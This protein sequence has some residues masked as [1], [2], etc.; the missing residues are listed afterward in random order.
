MIFFSA[1]HLFSA[2]SR[3]WTV[4][5]GSLQATK[6]LF[7]WSVSRQRNCWVSG[8]GQIQAMLFK[9]GLGFGGG[10]RAHVGSGLTWVGSHPRCC[11]RKCP[12]ITSLP[13]GQWR[14]HEQEV[15]TIWQ[16]GQQWRFGARVQ[17]SGGLWLWRVGG[18]T[19]QLL[20]SNGRLLQR[21]KRPSGSDLAGQV[22]GTSVLLPFAHPGAL[23]L[24][25]V[26]CVVGVLPGW[27]GG[28]RWWTGFL[29]KEV[30]HLQWL[31]YVSCRCGGWLGCWDLKEGCVWWLWPQLLCKRELL[32]ALKGCLGFEVLLVSG[33]LQGGRQAGLERD[34]TDR[35]VQWEGGGDEACGARGLGKGGWGKWSR[36]CRALWWKLCWQRGRTVE[37]CWTLRYVIWPSLWCRQVALENSPFC[38]L[39]G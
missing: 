26:L 3:L 17:G 33:M 14:W 25:I 12:R 30:G 19:P 6:W 11:G 1:S 34:G 22:L 31:R 24:H 15:Q 38:F 20:R 13:Q 8:G 10:Q 36:L 29:P 18:W 28:K 5:L 2:G 35:H 16:W 4:V 39:L 7:Y 23:C 32:L 37:N 27:W 21:Q 9:R